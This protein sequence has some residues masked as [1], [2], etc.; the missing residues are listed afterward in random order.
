MFV[1]RFCTWI[2]LNM[3]PQ[4]KKPKRLLAL[5]ANFCVFP[6]SRLTISCVH[7]SAQALVEKNKIECDVA[8]RLKKRN[9]VF[10]KMQ[11]IN[12]RRRIFDIEPSAT[13]WRQQTH[14]DN[15]CEACRKKCDECSAFNLDHKPWPHLRCRMPVR[16]CTHFQLKWKD[17]TIRSHN[18]EVNEG[19]K[20]MRTE[21]QIWNYI[22]SQFRFLEFWAKM[23]GLILDFCFY[24]IINSS[25][26]SFQHFTQ[27]LIEKLCWRKMLRF[28]SWAQM[29]RI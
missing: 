15:K 25:K 11:M 23:R 16:T 14:C 8:S 10:P 13:G 20:L 9:C 22:F 18:D 2:D 4:R 17:D 7:I 26:Y 19:R 28:E 5:C 24:I 6:S 3:D 29:F 1:T 27:C 21:A 12:K